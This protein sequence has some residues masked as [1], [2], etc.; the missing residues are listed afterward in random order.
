[1][2]GWVAFWVVLYLLVGIGVARLVYILFQALVAEMAPFQARMFY[3]VP[4]WR[5]EGIVTLLWPIFLFLMVF[6]LWGAELNV[7]VTVREDEEDMPV[8]EGDR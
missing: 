2:I 8:K 4:K 3:A 1:M 5:V 7:S 6:V